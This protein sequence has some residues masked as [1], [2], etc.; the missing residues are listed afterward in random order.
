MDDAFISFFENFASGLEDITDGMDEAK[1]LAMS[2]KA[3]VFS[4]WA[5]VY[6]Q[7]KLAGV[8][9]DTDKEARDKAIKEIAEKIGAI[10]S[11]EARDILCGACATVVGPDN[12]TKGEVLGQLL[13]DGKMSVSA[14]L[15]AAR[16]LLDNSADND[17]WRQPLAL[18]QHLLKRLTLGFPVLSSHWFYDCYHTWRVYE[19]ELVRLY[20]ICIAITSK[21]P[22]RTL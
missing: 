12:G 1:S 9:P 15:A 7:K 14:T 17:T 22:L 13:K 2:R 21:M 6:L 19:S 18:F 11:G 8:P 4:L 10:G 5:S 16:W 20:N 3:G